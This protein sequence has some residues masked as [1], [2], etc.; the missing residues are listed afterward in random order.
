[1]NELIVDG[2]DDI[3]GR[4]SDGV[5]G[6]DDD[7]AAGETDHDGISGESSVGVDGRLLGLGCEDGRLISWNEDGVWGRDRRTSMLVGWIGLVRWPDT[8]ES[9]SDGPIPRYCTRRLESPLLILV[10]YP[11]VA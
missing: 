6:C 3:E 1:M 11:S 8:R 2:E 4:V 7:E 9:K 5:D 10:I